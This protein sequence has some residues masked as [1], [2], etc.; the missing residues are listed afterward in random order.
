[1]S[2]MGLADAVRA[3]TGT[4][5]ATGSGVGLTACCS[6]RVR[7]FGMAAGVA[8]RSDQVEVARRREQG[9]GSLIELDV[10]DGLMGLPVGLAVARDELTARERALVDRSPAGALERDG[11]RVVRRVVAPVTVQFAVVGARDWRAGLERAGQFAP[12]CARAMLLPA[13][14]TD[15]GDAQAQASYFGVGVCVSFDQELHMLV[16]PRPYVRKRHTPAQ[17]WFA[18]EAYRQISEYE[19]AEKQAQ[20]TSA[21]REAQPTP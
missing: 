2:S 12:F 13:P 19:C 15:W 3:A 4:S 8:Y 20:S 21:R 11:E 16:E 9:F 7:I 5:L 14:P 6:A 10:L 18:E 17:W 1:M